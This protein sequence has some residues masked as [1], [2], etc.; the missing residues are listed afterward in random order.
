MTLLRP[1]Y[2]YVLALGVPIVALYLLRTRR[3]EAV[4]SSL[5][6]WE[7]ILR[8][9]HTAALWGRL[10]K[11]LSLLIQ[12]LVL[13]LI[14]L[15]L[16]QPVLAGRKPSRVRHVLLIDVS[17]SMQA[18]HDGIPRI[19]EAKH[20]AVRRIDA[21]GPDDQMMLI[22]V[23]DTPRIL[24]PF[25]SDHKTLR[26]AANR[27]SATSLPT[28]FT[29]A[30]RLAVELPAAG[31]RKAICVVSDGGFRPPDGAVPERTD[32][33][34]V[35]VGHSANNA[36]ITAF[37][38]RALPMSPQDYEIMA[39]LRW[40]GEGGLRTT[41][42]LW[43]DGKVMDVRPVSIPANGVRTE[44]FSSLR[45]AGRKVR[46][47]LRH[48]DAFPL[49]NDAYAV[50]PDLSPLRV[51]LVSEG[52]PFLEAALVS[53]ETV[54][55][56]RVAPSAYRGT[57][58]YDVVVFDRW[59]PPQAS[60]GKFILVGTRGRCV[61]LV[62]SH[63]SP[64]AYVTEWDRGHPL[65]RAVE[66]HRVC[67]PLLLGVRPAALDT[68]V[69]KSGDL[70]V[71]ITGRR[72]KQRFV[73]FPFDVRQ[74]DI[75]LRVAFPLLVSNSLRYVT[76]SG[77]GAFL[78]AWK[79]GEVWTPRPRSPAVRIQTPAGAKIKSPNGAV[80]LTECGFYEASISSGPSRALIASN[81]CNMHE[82]ELSVRPRLQIDGRT[83]KRPPDSARVQA[84]LW[85][86]LI[87]AVLA[88]S[89]LEWFLF[90][91]RILE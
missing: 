37:Q 85:Q 29:E 60:A 67:V 79:T 36:A 64:N 71:I 8:E 12:L 83:A 9:E 88:V 32:L 89:G 75:P 17:A 21:L 61:G 57:S 84:S 46:A 77:A 41:L 48:N 82:S 42:E 76:G 7:E 65:M 56:D 40:F 69:A 74:G 38:S 59:E 2:L 66:L 23:A 70:P 6:F 47:H 27:L 34:Y 1:I 14:A 19:E 5:M 68:V 73:L 49:D 28:D 22:G 33:Y 45:V 25:T 86:W 4:V 78:R 31:F 3:R 63:D 35:P 58:H 18:V 91:R 62:P 53:D 44:T 72:A 39:E 26:E 52:N 43:I 55:A 15:A 54:E 24:C 51:L 20:A 16:A 30:I 13:S 80:R 10:R 11:L 87:L 50:L 81:L 90:H